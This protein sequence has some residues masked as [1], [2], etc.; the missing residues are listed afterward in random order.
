MTAPVITTIT[1]RKDY[2]FLLTPR[3]A[4]HALLHLN[5]SLARFILPVLIS[6]GTAVAPGGQAMRRVQSRA[7]KIS[8][9]PC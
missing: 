9:F 4:D 2:S 5:L 8:F 3:R 6:C 7:P 1:I